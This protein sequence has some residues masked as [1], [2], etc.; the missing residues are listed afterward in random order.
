MIHEPSVDRRF[1]LNA[2]DA[3]A[4]IGVDLPALC[5]RRGVANPLDEPGERI[6][7][8]A[9][10]H[11]YDLIGEE[12]NDPEYVYKVTSQASLEGAG[13]LFQLVSCC[14]TMLD[15]VRLVCR[16]SSIASDVVAYSI[17]ERGHHVDFLVTPNRNV[18]VTL[19][20]VE[21]AVYVLTQYRRMTPASRG[22]LVVEAYFG[23]GPRFP[24]ARYE[25]HFGC[26]VHF[27]QQRTG[28][29]LSRAALDT[30]LPGADE[31]L[32]A[33]YRSVAERYESSIGAGDALPKRVQRLF[34][35]RMAFGEPD[36]EDIARALNTSVRTMQRQLREQ[37]ASYRELIESARL[38]AGKQELLASERPVHEIA[39][40]VGYAD[41][42]SFR[43]AFQ[44]WTG[45]A[46]ADFRREERR[47]E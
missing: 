5:A 46:P 29:R 30:P 25:Q 23:H 9:V 17:H 45:Q 27:G 47:A 10:S 24:A 44:R 13:T 36:R 12:L 2:V 4:R 22:P 18:Y 21:A 16:Y 39:F 32:Q 14:A 37:G 34:L 20:Q 28:L 19:H 43:R 31:R 41:V 1:F 40:L 42:R 7:L 35:Q 33:Y 26:P 8:R 15:A 6:P 38:S 11:V 3:I